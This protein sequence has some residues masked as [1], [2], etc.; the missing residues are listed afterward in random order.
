[1]TAGEGSLARNFIPFWVFLGLW[2]G[3]LFLSLIPSWADGT[4][5]D[6]GFLVPPIAVMMFLGRWNEIVPKSDYQRILSSIANTLRSPVIWFFGIAALVAVTLLRLIESVDSGWRVPLYLHWVIVW[7]FVGLLFSRFLT[8]RE[9]LQFTPILVLTLLGIPLPSFIEHSLIQGLTDQVIETSVALNR[10]GGYP[11]DIS[12]Q[13]IFAN[14]IPLRVSD[15]CSGIRSFQSSIFAGFV[16]GELLRLKWFIR[17]F[18]IIAGGTVAFLGNCARVVFLVK[19]VF[20][21][22]DVDLQ[23][24]HDIS[25]YV[26]LTLTLVV[27]LGIGFILERY[28]FAASKNHSR[29][30]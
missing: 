1:M 25:G 16:I 4:Y 5:Y 20:D 28:K 15:G 10:F 29:T 19:H 9:T 3:Q 13:T 21:H 24:L 18:L 30:Q 17:I 23:K 2:F 22:G 6:Y 8:P 7:A 11:L 12:G 14:G 26:S 27:I